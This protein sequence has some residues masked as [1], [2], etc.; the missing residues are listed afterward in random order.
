[1]ISRYLPEDFAPGRGVV[2]LA[3]K[4]RYPELTTERLRNAGIPVKLVAFEDET[5]PDFAATFPD[6]D[7]AWIKVGQ[8]GHLLD[9]LQRF[10]AGYTLMAGQITPR[11]LFKGLVPDVKAVM[12]LA[13]LKEKNAGTIFGALAGE[14][15]RAGYTPLD[16]RAF[17]D[18]QLAT[19]GNMSSS[20][21]RSARIPATTLNHGTRIAKEV[22]RLDIGQ[23][24]V[25][26]G[27][28][29][30]AVEAF[31]GTDKMLRRCAGIGA[32]A[33]LFV[34]T[35]KP[36]QD[37]RFDVPCFGLRT[38]ESMAEGGIRHAALEA[39]N[40]LILEKEKVLRQ[41]REF[42]ITLHGYLTPDTTA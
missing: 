32:R 16:A 23:G 11:R 3:G 38:L 18:D 40:V 10:R 27:T 28:T 30:I 34:K 21:W 20:G 35:V 8:L 31:E 36:D 42:G 37:Y 22:A 13:K 17:L 12:I 9:A 26:S 7:T 2:V 14:I 29:T 1:M 25:V 4:G 15:I 6:N 19:P 39:N 41:A 24:V 33:P 5:N